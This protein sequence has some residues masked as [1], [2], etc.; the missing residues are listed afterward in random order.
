[1]VRSWLLALLLGSWLLGAELWV[2]IGKIGGDPVCSNEYALGYEAEFELGQ[3]WLTGFDVSYKYAS[4]KEVEA[5]GDHEG[6]GPAIRSQRIEEHA[7]DV[8]GLLG[9]HLAY[10]DKLFAVGGLR[11][12]DSEGEFIYGLGLG[13]EYQHI[14][15]DRWILSLDLIRHFMKGEERYYQTTTFMVKVGYEF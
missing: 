3:E 11:L 13:A 1:M 7:F 15:E 4:L 5:E 10:H 12:G 2:G 8:E 6:E 9:K 14:F